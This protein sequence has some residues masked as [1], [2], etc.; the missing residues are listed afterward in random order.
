MDYEDVP[1]HP[2]VVVADLLLDRFGTDVQPMD[3]DIPSIEEDDM[4][5]LAKEASTPLYTGSR[6]NRLSIILQFLKVQARHTVSNVC[7][8]EIFDIIANHVID[9]NLESKMPKT[10]AEARKVITELGLD[11]K[12]IHSCPFDAILYYKENEDLQAC[13]KC[14]LSRYRQDTLSKSVPRK[15]KYT[16]HMPLISM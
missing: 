10:R 16:L 9:P 1:E 8:D 12:T 5:Y 3:K 14:N 11:Y 6:S 13:P 4:N 15:V 7:M 2:D